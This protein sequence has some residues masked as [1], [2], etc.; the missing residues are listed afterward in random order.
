MLRRD[1]AGLERRRNETVYRRDREEAPVARGGERVPR[2]LREEERA[3]HEQRLQLVPLLLGK[4]PHRR[5]VLEAGVRDDR[6]EPAVE[7]LERGVDDGTIPGAR[8]QVRVVDVDAVDEPP[9]V[10]EPLDDRGADAARRPGHENTSVHD[11]SSTRRDETTTT[12]RLWRG[13]S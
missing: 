9:V 13:R 1:V 12:P 2:V 4:V 3:R 8:R 6:V 7:P 11:A 10:G 5:N